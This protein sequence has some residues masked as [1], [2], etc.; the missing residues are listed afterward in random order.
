MNSAP[1]VRTLD[2]SDAELDT[3]SGGL[4]PQITVTA[5]DTTLSSDDVLAQL[6]GV[7]ATAL[8][9]LGGTLGALPHQVSVTA[10]L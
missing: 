8:G 6:D 10:G 9:A 4:A 5:G 2:L 3:V 7:K 1:Q